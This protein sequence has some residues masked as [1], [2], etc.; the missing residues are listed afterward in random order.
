M[1]NQRLKVKESKQVDPSKNRIIKPNDPRIQQ[2]PEA[3]LTKLPPEIPT[4]LSPY[5]ENRDFVNLSRS[6]VTLYSGTHEKRSLIQLLNAILHD[7][8]STIS[9]VLD[10]YPQLLF[11]IPEDFGIRQIGS[12]YTRLQ[13]LT[14][15]ESVF[16]MTQKL[17]LVH[18]VEVM[19]TYFFNELVRV[20]ECDEKGG[21][22]EL[23]KL[24]IMKVP[25]LEEQ[26]GIREKYIQDFLS[27][28]IA[29][30][31][32]DT[33]IRVDV[34]KI[35]GTTCSYEKIIRYTNFDK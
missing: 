8:L 11:A 9:K 22:S 30:I 23:E 15:G 12:H 27:A 16:S 34:R 4:A 26:K 32:A 33:T 28:P 35:P 21:A 24:F 31:L 2:A 17:N 25:T 3:G 18:I 19:F 1:Q 14:E 7:D 29:A 13:Y 20:R 5:L 10:T 6:C